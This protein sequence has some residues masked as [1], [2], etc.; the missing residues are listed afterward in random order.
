V[1]CARALAL[2][3][4]IQLPKPLWH[5]VMEFCGGELSEISKLEFQKRTDLK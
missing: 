3:Q 5:E 1:A 2:K 4:C